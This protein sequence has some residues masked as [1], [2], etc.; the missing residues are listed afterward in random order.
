MRSSDV[1]LSEIDW[2]FVNLENEGV[3]RFHWYP[4]TF[5]AALPG[6]LI[7][8]LSEAGDLVLDPFCGVGTT[9]LEA[10]RLGRRFA[11]ID[12]NPIAILIARA[13]LSFPNTKE[14]VAAFGLM[15]TVWSV[16]AAPAARGFGHPN[17]DELLDWYHP[18]TYRELVDILLTIRKCRD[19]RI[20]IAAQAAFSSILK[21][22]SSQPRHWGWVCD[23]VKPRKEEIRYKNARAAFSDAIGS[24]AKGI[25]WVLKDM[26]SRGVAGTRDQLR[27]TCR[28][29]CDDAVHRMGHLA[30]GSVDLVVTSPPY[31]GVAD[32]VKSQRLSFLW[33]DRSVLPVEGY[34]TADFESLRL[35]EIGCRSFRHR[36]TSYYEYTQF[37][38]SFLKS[39]I[40]VLKSGA[41]LCLVFGQSRAREKTLDVLHQY[42]VQ[43]GFQEL[44]RGSREIRETRRRLMAKVPSEEIIVYTSGG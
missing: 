23:N 41:R 12:T 40:R 9:G 8:L 30:D 28:V 7:P 14:L 36:Q 31:Y 25:E 39:S 33:F 17:E 18:T 44:F 15:G 32:Y 37:M 19:A 26:R 43:A 24:F 27:R 13:K 20:R 35:R 6:S 1:K 11:G 34:S 16:D 4:A 38:D 22:V 2:D 29:F 5:L 21:N 10:A 3:Y 42:A